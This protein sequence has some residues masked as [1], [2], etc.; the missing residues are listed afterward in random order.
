MQMKKM[1][2]FFKIN[3]IKE[4]EITNT[5]LNNNKIN[6]TNIKLNFKK[7]FGKITKRIGYSFYCL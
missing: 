6:L 7:P 4:N 1:K 2:Y 5:K 3:L